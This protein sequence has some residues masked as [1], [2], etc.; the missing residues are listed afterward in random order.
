M[1]ACVIVN[2]CVYTATVMHYLTAEVLEVAEDGT[3][4]AKT[5]QIQLV[6]A[7]LA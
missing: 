7:A 1:A 3:E 4:Q 5:K 6:V 2:A